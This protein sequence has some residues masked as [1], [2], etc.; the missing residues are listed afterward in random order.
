L[1]PQEQL[2]ACVYI[3]QMLSDCYAI[4]L[5]FRYDEITQTFFLLAENQRKE[6]LQAV[7]F[8]NGEWRFID[9]N[10]RL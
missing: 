4:I 10:T 6:E 9:D 3:C 7:I 8:S 1:L 2:F 5:M